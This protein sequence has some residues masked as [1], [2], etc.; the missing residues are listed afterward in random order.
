[1]RSPPHADTESRA[2][3]R[4]AHRWP[5]QL[6]PPTTP[7]P[8]SSAARRADRSRAAHLRPRP[9]SFEA[10]QPSPASSQS[11]P[12]RARAPP[13]PSGSRCS[14]LTRGTSID[15]AIAAARPAESDA[16]FAALLQGPS[17]CSPRPPCGYAFRPRAGET[18]VTESLLSPSLPLRQTATAR[19]ALPR[20]PSVCPCPP[21][22]C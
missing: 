3:P 8:R 7:R 22:L 14:A 12:R 19:T 10:A 16:G 6:C 9:V 5:L 11:A 1:L 2:A 13:P 4:C 20:T 18:N 15:L 21:S 17:R